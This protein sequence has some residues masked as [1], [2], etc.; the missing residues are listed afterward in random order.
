M[1]IKSILIQLL[2]AALISIAFGAVSLFLLPQMVKV[3]FW[4]G[5]Y[6]AATPIIPS[7]LIYALV[8][9]GGGPAFVL[10]AATCSIFFWTC[11]FAG[12][13]TAYKKFF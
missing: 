4:P 12:L 9:D 13:Y 6:I 5:M 8:P 3:Y 11:L 1:K 2:V 10:V 7:Q